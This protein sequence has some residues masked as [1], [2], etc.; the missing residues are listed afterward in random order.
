MIR[1][2]SPFLFVLFVTLN[3]SRYLSIVSARIL[4]NVI[5][6]F[7]QFRE[8]S[9]LQLH[10]V[11]MCQTKEHLDSIIQANYD[12]AMEKAIQ[13]DSFFHA[14]LLYYSSISPQNLVNL[15]KYMGSLSPS[16]N[17]PFHLDLSRHVSSYQGYYLNNSLHS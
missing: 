1:S 17:L 15:L 14:I 5:Y 10:H 3:L 4:W 6:R 13:L 16:H 11:H 9:E 7:H 2:Y 12:A 8:S